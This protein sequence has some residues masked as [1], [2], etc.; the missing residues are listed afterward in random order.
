MDENGFAVYGRMVIVARHENTGADRAGS[1]EGLGRVV[2][3]TVAGPALRL[4]VN[5]TIDLKTS[6]YGKA[7]QKG[8]V[9]Q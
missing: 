3:D 9:S 7:L 6:E 5:G 1:T 8:H 2:N 4:I